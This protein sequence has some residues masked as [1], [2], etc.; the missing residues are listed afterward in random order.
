MFFWYRLTRVLPDK[1][2][3]AVKRLCVCVCVCVITA[4][5][6]QVAVFKFTLKP[7]TFAFYPLPDLQEKV[8]VAVFTST[9]RRPFSGGLCMLQ[10][11]R[12]FRRTFFNVV[13][14]GKAASIAGMCIMP[15]EF[16]ARLSD[17]GQYCPVSLAEGELVDCSSYNRLTYAAEFQGR[18]H[19]LEH[20]QGGP[21]NEATL[22]FPKY[23]ENY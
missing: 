6:Y 11:I 22:H 19:L 9:L 10:V 18:F 7:I 15:E 3:R 2:H 21:K 17:F 4:L 1:F 14:S 12:I 20:V 5:V 13:L 16:K 23:L 8:V